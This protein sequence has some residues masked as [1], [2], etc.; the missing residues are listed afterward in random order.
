MGRVKQ[1]IDISATLAAMAEPL[2]LRILLILESSELSVGEIV[3]VVQLP[4]STVSR[5]LKALSDV[6]L[7]AKRA[8]G[9]ATLFR[10]VLDDLS[11]PLRTLWLAVRAQVTKSAESE[12]DARRLQAVLA[13]RRL[14]SQAFFGRIA[15]EWDD[16]RSRLFGSDF[17]ARALLAMLPKTWTVADL[18]C[19]T[20]NATE[21]L[22][23]HV[24]RVIAI[25]QSEPMLEAAR[26]RLKGFSNVTF[27]AGSL[28][29]LPLKDKSVDAAVCILVLHHIPEPLR[30]LKEMRRILRSG[31]SASTGHI[32]VVDMT[33][34]DR[35]E[36]RHTMGHSHLGFSAAA[37]TKLLAE[38]GFK[39][40]RI[41]DLP[42]DPEGKGPGLFAATARA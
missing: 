31:S 35:E 32:L 14:D 7:L 6:G 8:A 13:E 17:T 39:D 33:E 11:L 28:D 30:A 23:P 4:Q 36:Y 37:I 34:H 40:P 29:K 18:G 24:E 41:T 16:V 42:S 3:K 2:R 12:N 20:G 38:A 22:A 21:L 25:D 10:I 1:D 26:L 27:A 15:G 19:G 9:T 5:H